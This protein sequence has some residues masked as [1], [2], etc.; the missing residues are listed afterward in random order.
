MPGAQ[1]TASRHR[2]APRVLRLRGRVILQSRRNNSRSSQL[3][4]HSGS[5]FCLGLV[6]PGAVCSGTEVPAGLRV[7]RR[8]GPG[9]GAAAWGSAGAPCS[10]AHWAVETTPSAPRRG[11]QD[12]CEPGCYCQT[13]AGPSIPHGR[14]MSLCYQCFKTLIKRSWLGARRR[15]ALPHHCPRAWA[16]GGGVALGAP[17]SSP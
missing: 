6:G 2:P 14:L 5:R 3:P 1:E 9:R 17:G 12:R 7:G 13:W 8:A 11:C 4:A 16:R 10:G 15:S